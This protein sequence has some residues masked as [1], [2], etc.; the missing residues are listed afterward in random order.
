MSPFCEPVDG[1]RST[2]SL[3]KPVGF[4]RLPSTASVAQG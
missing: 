2:R 1:A 4:P 3:N